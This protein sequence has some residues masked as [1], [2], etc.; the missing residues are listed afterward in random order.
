MLPV[1]LPES[2]PTTVP[3][4]ITMAAP[5]AAQRRQ[6]SSSPGWAVPALTAPDPCAVATRRLRSVRGPIRSGDDI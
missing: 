2:E 4:A 1:R 6:Y 5:P 3:P